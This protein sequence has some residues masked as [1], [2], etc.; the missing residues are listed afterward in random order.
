MK[1]FTLLATLVAAALTAQ[2]APQPTAVPV[3]RRDNILSPRQGGNS[4]LQSFISASSDAF[5]SSVTASRS[6][7]AFSTATGTAC[8][9]IPREEQE[10][11]N[12]NDDNDDDTENDASA[13][14]NTGIVINEQCFVVPGAEGVTF[15]GEI[16]GD[17][18][19]D[20]DDDNDNNNNNSSSSS[21][22]AAPSSTAADNDDNDDDD[23]NDNDNSSSS[24]A[25]APTA[26]SQNGGSN[27]A[28]TLEAS[29]GL[30]VAGFLGLAVAL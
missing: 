14:C 25:A 3:A 11:D 19:D 29:V 7:T 4:A 20:D 22:A 17:D 13:C 5:M 27:G 24:A 10:N 23:D 18:D 21:S 9:G 8:R 12:D 26:S 15:R 2:A 1:T 6:T 28:N 30:M 16:D